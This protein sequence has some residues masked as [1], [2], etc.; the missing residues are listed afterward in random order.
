MQY[1]VDVSHT[2]WKTHGV[3]VQNYLSKLP[4]N[5]K[6][7]S[8]PKLSPWTRNPFTFSIRLLDAE[9]LHSPQGTNQWAQHQKKEK[10]TNFKSATA[11]LSL[12]VQLVEQ[13]TLLEL[14]QGLPAGLHQWPGRPAQ[15][16]PGDRTGRY[17]HMITP[18]CT[19]GLEFRFTPESTP[20]HMTMTMKS[21]HT[22]EL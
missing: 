19:S 6:D 5:Y 14:S 22:N 9:V 20:N 10:K 8:K 2:K 4:D 11:L 13:N 1:L 3:H 17:A 18:T 21:S 16:P 15:R 7:T 12:I